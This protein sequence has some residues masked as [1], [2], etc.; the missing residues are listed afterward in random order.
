[1]TR[2][3]QIPWRLGYCGCSDRNHRYD[4][5]S[6]RYLAMDKINWIEGLRWCFQSEV[7]LL[8]IDS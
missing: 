5:I 7:E 1:M 6:H 3:R 8:Y 4:G 2:Q